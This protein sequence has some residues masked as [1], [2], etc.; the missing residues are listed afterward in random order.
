[1]HL[2]CAGSGGH[3]PLALMVYINTCLGGL[4]VLT[5]SQAKQQQ[6]E[7]DDELTHVLCYMC[8]VDEQDDQPLTALC[9]TM[10]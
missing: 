1:M 4:D 10:L 3:N 9:K 5:L 6:Q 8:A 7:E 2:G